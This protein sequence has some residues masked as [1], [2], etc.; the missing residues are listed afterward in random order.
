MKKIRSVKNCFFLTVLTGTFMIGL[1]YFSQLSLHIQYLRSVQQDVSASLNQVFNA[2]IGRTVNIAPVPALIK[3]TPRRKY[4]LLI[5]SY[6]N[7]GSRFTGQLFG[8]RQG[9]FYVYEPLWKFSVFDYFRPENLVCSSTQGSTNCMKG[10]AEG[11]NKKKEKGR[12][13]YVVRNVAKNSSIVSM[14][15]DVLYDIYNCNFSRLENLFVPSVHDAPDLAGPDWNEF[16]ECIKS[17]TRTKQSC[18]NQRELRCKNATH[19]VTKV[20]RL[21]MDSYDKLL[22]KR[23]NLKI[24]HLFRNP[25]AIVNSRT[26]SRGYPVKDWVSNAAVLCTKMQLDFEGTVRLGKKYPGRVKM[27]FYE[28]LKSN[29]TAKIR[30]LYEYIGMENDLTEVKKLNKVKTNKANSNTPSMSRTRAADNAHWWRNHLAFSRYQSI[31]GKCSNMMKYFNLTDFKDRSELM[32][33][34]LPEMNLPQNLRI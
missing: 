26:E 9:A 30:N 20:L 15:I 27:V 34:N 14:M 21:T 17:R 3:P 33:L 19:R 7:S 23:P 8:F 1:V 22:E 24:L 16:R 29:V 32:K 10:S 18:L 28:D 13:T 11:L 5:N 2:T 25:F 6:M 31:K 4:D 12:T